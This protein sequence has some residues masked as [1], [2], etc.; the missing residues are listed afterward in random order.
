MEIEIKYA[1]GKMTINAEVFLDSGGV[2]AFRKLVKMSGK[3]DTAYG[4]NTISEWNTV[5]SKEIS[6][7]ENM[8]DKS[9][10]QERRKNKLEKFKFILEKMTES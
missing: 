1:S 6:L 10:V 9:K 7:S 5:I 4:T 8:S 3:S 2:A